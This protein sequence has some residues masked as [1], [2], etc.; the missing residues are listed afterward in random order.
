MKILLF[1]KI[2]QLGWEL[3]RSLPTLG[4]VVCF[5]FPEVDFTH[6]ETL[7][8]LVS[9]VHPDVIVNAAAYTAVDRAEEQPE[10]ARLVNSTAPGELAEAAHKLKIPLIHYSTD[11]VFDGRKG[12][13]YQETDLP[14]PLNVYGQ[15]KL[16]GE[17]AVAQV[18][19][20]HLILR[21]SWVYSLRQGGFVIKVLEWARQKPVMNVV[22]DQV[23]SPT[24]ARFLAEVTSQILAGGRDDLNGW[25][26]ER[27]GLYHLAGDG[28]ASR[29]DW[30]LA[31][32]KNDPHKSEQI[33]HEIKP[34][35]TAE[36]PTLAPRPAFSALDCSKF[37][38]TFGLSL[39]P[40]Q[41][42]L[43]LALQL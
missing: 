38:Q 2:G 32:L 21:A 7:N 20:A 34:A 26:G 35:Y 1:G 17:Q 31:I 10:I 9:E 43:E 33:V 8:P 14:H 27:K 37:Q 23:G 29:F 39:P 13:T 28:A 4:E 40:W 18:G 36:F 11:Y 42:A 12:S 3:R 22:T 41:L 30:A 6:P 16:E 5:D 19:G 24:W 15:S 25:L